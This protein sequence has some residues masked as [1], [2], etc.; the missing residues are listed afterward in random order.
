MKFTKQTLVAVTALTIGNASMATE[1][2]QYDKPVSI[3]ITFKYHIDDNLAEQDVFVQRTARSDVVYRPSV[4]ERDMSLPLYAAAAPVKHQPFDENAVGPYDKGEAL[5]ITLGDW[6]QGEGKGTYTCVDSEGH[7]DVTF[8]N[9]VPNGTYTM[10]H[11]FLAWPPTD[12]FI[13]AYDLPIGA[14]DGSEAVFHANAEGGAHVERIFKPCLQL[15]GEHL[16]S[17]LAIA[18]HSDGKTYGPL[19][20]EFAKNSHVQMYMDLPKRSGI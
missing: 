10:W 14:R 20:G 3:D 5:G 6:F 9:L 15:T 16:A 7:L 17:G 11:Y 12:P 8:T 19:P 18:W 1:S 13:G 2:L 4:G